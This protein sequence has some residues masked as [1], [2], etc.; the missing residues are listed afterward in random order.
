MT[1]S[2]FNP[3][4]GSPIKLAAIDLAL[5][6]DPSEDKIIGGCERGIEW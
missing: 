4:H 5:R 2:P 1:S 3:T 6:D